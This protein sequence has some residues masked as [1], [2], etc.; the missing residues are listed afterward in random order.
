M[1]G[2]PVVALADVEVVPARPD[3]GFNFSYLLRS[4]PAP[5]SASTVLLVETNNTG[6]PSDDDD[7]HL[8]AAFEVANKGFGSG[9]AYS[10]DVPMLVPVFPRPKAESLIYTHALDR[11]TLEIDVGPLRRIDLQLIAMVDDA[12][13]RLA[14]RHMKIRHRIVLV[15]FSASGTF[16]N[17]FTA[18][19]PERVLA[20]AVGGI[21]ALAILPTPRL[22]KAI[23]PYPLGVSDFRRL[24]G[25]SFDLRA[26]RRV[27]QFVFMGAKDTND[28]VGFDDAYSSSERALVY[29][30]IGREML[31]TRWGRCREVYVAARANATFKTYEGIGHGTDGVIRREVVEFI[32]REI[33][34]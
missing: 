22:G 4:A 1:L 32:R 14:T 17:R 10:L 18:L 34:R 23:L 2:V 21:N 25:R 9:I 15:G 26:W 28:A 6:A 30:Q 8:R 19:H 27:P 13:K 12:R 33:D 29:D 24:T 31:P 7:V 16:A 20:V 3:S 5:A 11:E